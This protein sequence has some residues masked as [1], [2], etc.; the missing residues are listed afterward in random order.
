MR[1]SS[2]GLKT[3]TQKCEDER[4]VNQ[5]ISD[6]CAGLKN[7]IQFLKTLNLKLEKEKLELSQKISAQIRAAQHYPIFEEEIAKL[8]AELEKSKKS[9][10]RNREIAPEKSK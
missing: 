7:E 1:R 8:K 6:R 2:A 4:L 5:S 9:E 3:L 10:W